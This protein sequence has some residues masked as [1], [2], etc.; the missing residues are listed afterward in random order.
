MPSLDPVYVPNHRNWNYSNNQKEFYSETL[1][2]TVKAIQFVQSTNFQ[3]RQPEFW[4]DGNPKFNIRM[5]FA[6][7]NG[8][9]ITFTFQPASKAAKEGRK[10]SIHIDLFNLAKSLGGNDLRS[11]ID[12]TIQISTKPGNY[13]PNNP[14]EFTVQ[15][16]QAGPFE[17]ANPLPDEFKVPEIV[18]SRPAVQQPQQ[19]Y[20]PQPM[21][22]Q[23]T[24][25]GYYAP[26]IAQPMPQYQQPM[27]PVQPMPQ[28][29][30][31][32]AP[33]APV[34]PVTP[35]QTG[36]DPAIA[37]AMQAMNAQTVTTPYDADIPF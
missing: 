19:Q 32:A 10:K 26:P 4:P 6:D 22:P 9:L 14:R 33:V 30:Q 11:L 5:A 15:A 37:A 28:Q 18:L 3:T 24:Q 1:V 34:V 36:I 12:K 29:F 7:Q 2:G 35:V 31:Q 16:V 20:A 21:A 27:Q 23:V 8:E 25:Q 13:G 17:L